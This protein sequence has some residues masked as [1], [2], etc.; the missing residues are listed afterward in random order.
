VDNEQENDMARKHSGSEETVVDF[1][2]DAPPERPYS[3][4]ISAE[5]KEIMNPS[6]PEEAT[7][8]E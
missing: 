1:M 5:Q 3:E 6:K 7:V 8:Q 4:A 2:A